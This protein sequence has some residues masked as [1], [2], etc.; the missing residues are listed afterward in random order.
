MTALMSPKDTL[1]R[2]SLIMGIQ[3]QEGSFY[4][5]E[6]YSVFLI[7][8]NFSYSDNLLKKIKKKYGLDDFGEELPHPSLPDC[9]VFVTTRKRTENVTESAAYYVFPDA[10]G[11]RM[12]G[13]QT[14]LDRDKAYEAWCV[15][16]VIK[17]DFP[18]TVYTPMVIDS[19]NFAGRK[20]VLGSLCNWH[21]TRNVQCRDYG[22]MNWSEFRHE[23]RALEMV[24]KQYEITAERTLGEV[25][26]ADS[27]EV[28][29]EG[30]MVVALKVLYKVKLPSIV[31]GGS[32]LLLVY[33]IAADVR[34]RYVACV[35]SQ[36]TYMSR[37]D[38]LAPL[39]RDIIGNKLH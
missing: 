10:G 27:V 5:A 32:N 2:V 21:S 11:T 1:D 26:S 18:E 38:V 35:L 14:V 29:F 25:L 3:Q 33:Y 37:L 36:Y 17:Q 39:L 4:D 12:V 34:G 13:M 9:R 24:K 19:F 15:A 7:Q 23:N 6:G 28:P 20:L 8:P 22:Q 31:T 16:K 30:K